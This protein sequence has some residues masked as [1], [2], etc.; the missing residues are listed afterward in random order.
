MR[1]LALLALVAC[2]SEGGDTA[3]FVETGPL[4]EVYDLECPEFGDDA[5]PTGVMVGAPAMPFVITAIRCHG[6]Y[7]WPAD[8]TV[9]DGQIMVD[10]VEGDDVCRVTLV[11]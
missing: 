2:A 5:F 8:W 11:R 9:T 3:A 6:N 4:M 7:C 1:I 10:F